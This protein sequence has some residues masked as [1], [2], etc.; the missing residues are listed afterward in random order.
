M[1]KNMNEEDFD[2]Y[3]DALLDTVLQFNQL[4]ADYVKEMDPELWKKAREYAKDFSKQHGIELADVSSKTPE[5]ILADLTR[6]T[7]FIKITAS[8][9]Q[10]M[11]E[12]YA[13]YVQKNS[14]LSVPELQQK[15]LKE[16]K[17]NE[18][19]KDDP[20]GTENDINLFIACDHKFSFD[21]FDDSDWMDYMYILMNCTKDT[22]FVKDFK[23]IIDQYHELRSD[24]YNYY[25]DCMKA[26]KDAIKLLRNN[27][28]RLTDPEEEANNEEE[29]E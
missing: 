14:K 28:L 25:R 23:P 27:Q 12:E 20:F 22:Q 2:K 29:N 1:E 13:E 21:K 26:Y 24:I 16:N 7:L 19:T 17:D 18:F 9:I 8:T 5:M 15:W 6:Q 10:Q 3:N 4:F 11:G